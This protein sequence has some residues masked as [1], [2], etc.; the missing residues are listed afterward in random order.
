MLR[1]GIPKNRYVDLTLAELDLWSQL[2]QDEELICAAE[3]LLSDEKQNLTAAI[4]GDLRLD[5][6]YLNDEQLMLL[7]WEDFGRGDAARDVGMM[8][9][10]WL[11]RSIL[12]TVTSRGDG[13]RPPEKFNEQSATTLIAARM[14][15]ATVHIGNFWKTY[16]NNREA[17]D[18]NLGLRATARLGWHLVERTIAR[19]G[20]VSKLSGIERAALS[21]GRR[22]LITPDA[23]QAALGLGENTNES[24]DNSTSSRG[25]TV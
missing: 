23:Y 15:E 6:F 1:H 10:E 19:A 9:G 11:Y 22:A 21:I 7:D 17:S 3:D 13:Q 18:P 20:M 4:H 16:K 12:D 8:A 5:Q 25:I 14:N 24:I 2:Q